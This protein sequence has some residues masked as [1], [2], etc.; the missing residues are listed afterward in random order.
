MRMRNEKLLVYSE[1]LRKM[2]KTTIKQMVESFGR[3]F[4]YVTILKKNFKFKQFN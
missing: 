1:D 2:S 4:I 3:L